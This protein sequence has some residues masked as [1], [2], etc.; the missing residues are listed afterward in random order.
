MK[1]LVIEDDVQTAAFVT[2]GLQQAGH[3]VDLAANGDVGFELAQTNPYDVLVVDRMLPGR[4]GLDLVAAL[5]QQEVL[6]PV[7]ILTALSSVDDRVEGL[8]AGADDYLGKPF[9]FTELL[10]RVKALHRRGAHGGADR[11]E[12]LRLGDMTIDF[13]RRRVT[14]GDRRIDL[15]LQE[16]KLLEFLARR[17]GEIVTRTMLLEN[18]W[19]YDFDPRTNIVEAHVSRL[20]AK[21][22]RGLEKSAL[23]TVRGIGYVLDEPV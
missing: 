15:T 6:T 17:A 3:T 7:L 13:R 10:A 9:A 4:M 11:D 5:R 19:G 14:R 22:D 23:R 21:I 2:K 18:L 1:L 20:R 8:E 16:Y 12:T